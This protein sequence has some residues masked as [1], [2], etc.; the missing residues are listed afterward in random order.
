M[1]FEK[2]GFGRSLN[3]PTMTSNIDVQPVICSLYLVLDSQSQI[4]NF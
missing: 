3:L 4:P 1:L 2:G